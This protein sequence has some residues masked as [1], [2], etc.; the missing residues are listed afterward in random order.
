MLVV[1][2]SVLCF[3]AFHS[4]LFPAHPRYHFQTIHFLALSAA[5][6]LTHVLRR[7]DEPGRG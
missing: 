3:T 2:L 6:L 1:P 5:A 4:V 7:P